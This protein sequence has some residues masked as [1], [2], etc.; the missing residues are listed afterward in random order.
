MGGKQP[1][2]DVGEPLMLTHREAAKKI[3]ISKSQLY[4]LLRRGELHN[5]DL[6]PQ[7]KRIAAAECVAYVDSLLAEQIGEA[8]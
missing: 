6:G 5:L 1:D 7:T 8:S 2:R 4:V 3:G